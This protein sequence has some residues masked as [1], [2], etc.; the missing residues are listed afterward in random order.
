MAYLR[1][2]LV[3]NAIVIQISCA[4]WLGVI[5]INGTPK[6]LSDLVN[7]GVISEDSVHA[8][9]AD[10][11]TSDRHE[12]MRQLLHLPRANGAVTAIMASSL[13]IAG[14]WFQRE[15]GMRRRRDGDRS[16]RN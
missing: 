1:S 6:L 16:R 2:C 7:G 3:L 14:L 5:F 12:N 11:Y 13:L 9:L 8:K 15:F 10:R 4:L